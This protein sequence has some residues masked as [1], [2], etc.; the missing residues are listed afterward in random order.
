VATHPTYSLQVEVS[1]GEGGVG[2][3]TV[4]IN[5]TKLA[6]IS[7]NVFVDVNHNGLFDA[8][9]PGIDGVTVRLLDASGTTVVDTAVTSNDG[10]YLFEG[11]QPGVYQV[12]E[13]QPT[14][15]TDGSEH[16]GSLGGTIV[17]NDR[18]KVTI[19]GTDATDYVIAEIGQQLKSGDTAGMGFWQNKHG[20]ELIAQG[21]MQ[22]ASWLTANFGNI[23][24]NTLVGMTAGQVASFYRDQVFKGMTKSGGT[25][26][27]DAQFMATA[28]A[29]FF[30]SKTLAGLVAVSYGVNVTDTGIGTKIVNVGTKGAAFSAANGTDRTIMELLLATNNLTDQANASSGYVAVYDANGNGAISA[31]ESNLRSLASDLYTSINNA[32][33]I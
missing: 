13:T 16:L 5:V 30:T 3:A 23:F 19:A 14:G 28:F 11:L 17:A 20:Q 27:V 6:N 10:L 8:N 22:L 26:K 18:M 1:D 33:G 21:G 4:T 7:G 29:T 32:G 15:V 2:T 25:P 12:A 24:G 9:E 31:A